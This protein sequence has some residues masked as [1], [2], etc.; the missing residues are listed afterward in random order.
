MARLESKEELEKLLDYETYLFDCD[1]VLWHGDHLIEGA[2]DVLSF[3]RSKQKRIIFVTNNASKSR[4]AY[5][6]KF[7]DLGVEAEVDEIFGS[8]YA[9]AVYLSSVL[10]FKKEDKVYIIGMSGVEE[11]L[12]AE[13]LTYCGGTDPADSKAG[14]FSLDDFVDDPT[15]KAVLCGLDVN[16][17]Y[18]KLS[19]A[20][21]YLTRNEGCHFIATNEDSTYPV[22][23]GVLPGSGAISAPL[24]Y[25]LKKDPVSIGK[26]KKAMLDAIV[27]KQQF[28]RKKAI[29][30][31]DRLDTDI[32]FGIDGGIDTLLV[33][34]GI[35]QEAEISGPNA[36]PVKPTYI[37]KSIGDLCVL[38]Q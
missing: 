29:M 31:G 2:L 24:R 21:Q 30:V 14:F 10:K 36:S 8:A 4:K 25:M 22:K 3:L 16:I 38:A 6:K 18:T 28:D 27:A 33:L 37:T 7:D 5:K 13:G 19:K 9:S 35:T 20:F 17:N 23:G 11:E 34:T 26:P 32:Q 12:E 1:G 15:I